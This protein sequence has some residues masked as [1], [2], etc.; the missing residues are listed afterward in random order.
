MNITIF[1]CFSLCGVLVVSGRSPKWLLLFLFDPQYDAFRYLWAYILPL[2]N[3]VFNFSNPYMLFFTS[4]VVRQSMLEALH[5]TKWII[6]TRNWCTIRFCYLPN[7][8]TI[9]EVFSLGWSSRYVLTEFSLRLHAIGT[10]T[11]AVTKLLICNSETY[12]QKS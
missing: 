12:I 6:I 4:S 7:A 10:R 1:A 5:L 11:Y 2:T 9:F 3:F 8:L